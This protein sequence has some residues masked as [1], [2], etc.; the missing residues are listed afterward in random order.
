MTGREP[1]T[2]RRGLTLGLTMA[3]IFILI[4][5]LLLLLL[6]ALYAFNTEQENELQETNHILVAIEKELAD[7][8]SDPETPVAVAEKTPVAEVMKKPVTDSIKKQQSELPKKIEKLVR[9]NKEL[10]ARLEQKRD[11]LPEEMKKLE[12]KNQALEDKLETSDT[13]LQ[14]TEEKLITAELFAKKGIDPPCWYQVVDRRGEPHEQPYYLMDIAVGDQNLNFKLLQAPP[15]SAID[16]QGQAAA[17]TYAQ[18]Y[19]KLPLLPL[20]EAGSSP[21]R[22]FIAMT[23][24][25][26]H[27]GDDKQIRHYACKFYARVWD[28]TSATAKERWKQAEDAIKQSFYTYRV[29]NDPWPYP[30]L[31]E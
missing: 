25:I 3:E 10:Q 4:L 5:F 19:E 24:P 26:K 13:R 17:T 9:D 14:E 7:V 18:E 20:S 11:S 28:L 16:E 27:M 31:V 30:Q 6:L 8:Q 2:Y 22:E 29:R 12:R 15:G 21:L 1:D 23:E